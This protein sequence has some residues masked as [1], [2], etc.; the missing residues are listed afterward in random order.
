M[1]IVDLVVLS[2]SSQAMHVQIRHKSTNSILHCS[3]IYAGNL[4]TVRRRLW[5]ELNVH[6]HVVK[7]KP[8][9]IMGDFNFALNIADSHLVRV[10]IS[11]GIKSLRVEMDGILKK[12]D[13]IMGNIEFIDSFPGA[14]AIFQPYPI[15]DHSPSVLKIPTLTSSKP[16]PFKFF[17]FITFKSKF[18]ELVA[19]FWK[20]NAESG[21]AAIKKPVF[22]PHPAV[23]AEVSLKKRQNTWLDVWYCVDGG[24]GICKHRGEYVE[25]QVA[26]ESAELVVEDEYRQ[27]DEERFLK[28]KAK[29]E[30]LDVG[31]SNSAYFNKVVNSSNQRSHIEVILNSNNVEVSGPSVP[32]VFVSHYEIFIGSN[33]SCADL[34]IDGLFQNKVSR[35]SYL[36]MVRKILN[37]EIKIAMFDIGDDRAPGLDGFTSAFFK[38][39]SPLLLE[40]MITD[41]SR[42]AMLFT[43][44]LPL[45]DITKTKS[46]E[47]LDSM[48]LDS[49]NI[50][51]K[52]TNSYV[53]VLQN[54]PITKVIKVLE[55]RNEE[56]VEGAA[57][58][59][60][61]EAFEEVSS[62]FSNTLFGYFIGKRLAFR[63]IETKDGMDSVLENGPW[64]IRMVPMILNV[65]SPNTDLKKAKVKKAPVSWGRSTYVRVLIEV[66]AEVD[67]MDSLM[68]AILVGR[69]KGH[70]LATINID[71]KSV[72]KPDENEGFVEVKHKKHK[73]KTQVHKLIEGVR[74]SK[75]PPKFQY[76]RVEKAKSSKVAEKQA[77]VLQN[78]MSKPSVT[79]K[80]SFSSLDLYDNNDELPSQ[81]I[82]VSN[83][84]LNVSDSDVDEEIVLDDRK[85]KNKGQAL[86]LT[87]FP[88]INIDTWNILGLNF[89]P[90]Q[91]EVKQVIS[92]NNISICAILE[93]HAV[94]S[95]LQRL[96]SHVFRHW[97]WSS[98][99]AFCVK[100]TRIILGWNH[101]DV[102]VVVI[103][104]P[105]CLLGDFNAA[106]YS[107]DSTGCSSSI[108]ISMREFKECVE[109]IEVLDVQQSGLKYTWNQKLKG[110]NGILKKLDRIMVNLEFNDVFV[111][112]HAIFKPY[113]VSDHSPSVLIIPILVETKSK[114]FKFY[115]ILTRNDHFRVVVQGVWNRPVSGFFMFRV[116]K[117]LKY[118]KKPFWKLLYDKGN[119]HA[120]VICL[121]KELDTVQTLL[122]ADPF[123]IQL[124]ESEAACVVEFNQAGDSNSAYFHKAVKSR[125]SRSRIDV[126]TITEGILFDNDKVSEAFVSHYEMFLGFAGETHGFNTINLFKTCLNEQVALDMVRDVSKQE[127]KEAIFSMGDDKSPGSDGY[128][129]AFFKEAWEIIGNDI[130]NAICEFFT[131]GTLLKE[132]NHT[133]IALILKVKCPSRVN[134]YRPISCCNVLFKCISK[135]IANRIKHS[136]KDLINPIQSVFVLGRSISDNILLTQELMHNYHLD[137]GTPRCAFKVDIQKA[138]DTVDWNF[139]RMVLHGF[140]FYPRMI[141]WIME[142]VTSTSYSICINGSLYGYFQGKR[143]LRQGD[144]L[145]PYLFTL[146]ME[147]LTLM[148][149]RRVVESGLF[150]YHRY[151]SKIELINLCFADDLFIFSYG[152]VQLVTIIKECWV[153]KRLHGFLEVTAAQV[154]NRSRIGINKEALEEFKLAS[155]LVPS[156]PKSIAFFFNV[157]N[158]TKISILNIIP[159]EEGRLPVK[160]LGVPLV[161][162]RLLVRDCK[163]LIER[164][165]RGFI[166]CQCDL[167]KGKAKVSWEVVCLP[168]D[169]GGLGLRRLEHFSSSLMVSHVWKL[170]SLKESLWV[171]WIHAYKLNGRSNGANTSLW[172]DHWCDN[173][174]FSTRIS[175]RDVFRAGLNL[176]TLV[177]DIIYDG[178]WIWPSFLLEKYPFLNSCSVPVNEG[179]LDKLEWRCNGVNK[180]FLPD[181]KRRMTK[182]VIVRLVIAAS[183][184][185]VW[186]ERN[187]RLFKSK[188]RTV[189]QVIDCV[190][191]SV[192]LKLLSCKLKKSKDGQK[193][194]TLW[195]LPEAIFV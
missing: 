59:I 192:S 70:S 57:I 32:D 25:Y 43:N 126:V 176:S 189:S 146:V 120:N 76:R 156:L 113:R 141:L 55:L 158:H 7:N 165:M 8:W 194:A 98:N 153:L 12:L 24:W 97:D 149:N 111:G 144:P 107:A 161:S 86:P 67:L 99:G 150:T 193:F 69:D 185:S 168:K 137:R 103:N 46:D 119:L 188:K 104:R 78:Q 118:L 65:W 89:S 178:S 10:F 48:G 175:T 49:A 51:T 84:V 155:G 41:L 123:N 135:V 109:N 35:M 30:W 50:H 3:F 23:G 68:I 124:H 72:E 125:V 121:R 21:Q 37:D 170:L 127:V 114:P 92:E 28:K 140:G 171:R 17:N 52:G 169:E 187:W 191:S 20:K 166:W 61:F 5:T 6:K 163:E 81:V 195:D 83:E 58:A 139:V 63:L 181:V 54:K 100:G 143:G 145:S 66:S 129:A 53:L 9:I 177:K 105:W 60:P 180:A 162:S 75:A 101:N 154:K 47:P 174:P 148:L 130:T 142:C 42:V 186:Q 117:K 77:N 45:N 31:D 38:K 85:C 147:I 18:L 167:K 34:N 116:V 183:A 106:L 115:N 79:I 190:V 159:F 26:A 172:Y 138:Y 179:A 13:C 11:P 133:I 151:C 110:S 136:L 22:P 40:L 16:K 62:R 14:Y 164:I 132:L 173:G 2:K 33:M 184:Y 128:T 56:I 74:L 122:D 91:T 96:C 71:N 73:A 182:S 19:E 87:W 4:P 160:Y 1:D 102:D 44:V 36:D 15:S 112:S 80:N 88:M 39:G 134:D 94:D 93:S 152:D 27:L 95:N 157:L 108:D 64:L 90:K 82:N 29:I 131:N